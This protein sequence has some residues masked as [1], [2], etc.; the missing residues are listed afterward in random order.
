M[1]LPEEKR[2]TTHE[3]RSDSEVC[4]IC[5]E[6]VSFTYPNS[7]KQILNNI[8]FKYNSSQSLALV[9]ENGS[10]KTT[11]I[12]LLCGLYT[13][14]SGKIT[15]DNV[16]INEMDYEEKKKYFSVIFQDFVKY[17]MS[18]RENVALGD[19]TK[20]YNDDKIYTVLKD[21]GFP[22]DTY[23]LEQQIGKFYDEGIDLSGGQWQKVAIAR[24]LYSDSK[25]IIL[26]EPTASLDPVAES[27]LYQLF[28]KIIHQRGYI[29]ISH[30][31]ASA[32]LCDKILVLQNG[33]IIEEGSHDE[34]MLQGGYYQKMYTKQ[35]EWYK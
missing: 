28:Q 13:P 22:I 32:K 14:D 17:Q 20:I 21:V 26:D 29:M 15:I 24:A 6:N 18:L 16:N 11:L 3:K 19:T 30:R 25:F 7:N 1:D 31:L 33:S 8:T 5:F 27:K 12:K 4:E 34:L 10:G 2:E 23:T 35:S 9:G